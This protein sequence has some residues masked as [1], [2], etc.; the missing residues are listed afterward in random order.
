MIMQ[1]FSLMQSPIVRNERAL[2]V[3][4][5]GGGAVTDGPGEGRVELHLSIEKSRARQLERDYLSSAR[6]R[7]AS[8]FP[9]KLPGELSAAAKA[10]RAPSLSPTFRDAIPRWY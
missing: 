4:V 8:S 10:L 9:A 5:L 1:L 2:A 6:A 7:L 3:G